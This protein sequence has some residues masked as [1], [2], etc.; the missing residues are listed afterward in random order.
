MITS[1]PTRKSETTIA[2]TV[3][4]V[5][6]AVPGDQLVYEIDGNRVILRRRDRAADTDLAALDHLLVEWHDPPNDVFD[7]L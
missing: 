6:H 1:E 5:L 3:R 4:E 7:G 2:L